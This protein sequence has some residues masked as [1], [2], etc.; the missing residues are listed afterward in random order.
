M[1]H[2]NPHTKAGTEIGRLQCDPPLK[3]TTPGDCEITNRPVKAEPQINWESHHRE[4]KER[5]KAIMNYG[6][7]TVVSIDLCYICNLLVTKW[8]L[9]E[10]SLNALLKNNIY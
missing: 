1:S 3:W 6:G 8:K 4:N 10:S 5:R 7:G 9:R 2:R